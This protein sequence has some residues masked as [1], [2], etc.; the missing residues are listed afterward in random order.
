LKYGKDTLALIDE[1]RNK[2]V[3]HVAVI[4]RHSAR[5]YDR[6]IR[7]FDNP[8][9]DEG[10]QLAY[11]WGRSLPKELSVR[12]YSSPVNRC[13]ETAEKIL[14]GHEEDGGK[15]HGRRDIEALGTNHILDFARFAMTVRNM[16][17]MDEMY[18]TWFAGKLAP[19]LL[20]PSHTL[21]TIT[22]HVILDKLRRPVGGP[23]LDILVSHDMNLYP[24]RH[25]LLNQTIDDYGKVYYLDGVVFYELDHKVHAQSHHGQAIPLVVG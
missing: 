7:D 11:D 17:S 21:A 4:M 3:E 10:R 23:Q 18:A 2:G 25:H 12:A 13:V 20:L 22:A 5:T 15:T 8:L 19:D 6:G 14:S 1:V 9:T 16:G 24:L